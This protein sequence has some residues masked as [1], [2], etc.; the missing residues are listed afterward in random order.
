MPPRPRRTARPPRPRRRRRRVRRARGADAHDLLAIIRPGPYICAEWD[1]SGL[2]SFPSPAPGAS[3]EPAGLR[4]SPA[5][6][7]STVMEC[8]YGRI[9]QDR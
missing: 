7:A 4:G 6:G 5:P 1:N 3:T 9:R 2:L 8:G